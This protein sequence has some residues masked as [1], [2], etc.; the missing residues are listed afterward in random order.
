[1]MDFDD[2]EEPPQLIA[3]D[4]PVSGPSATPNAAAVT[5]DLEELQ[6]KKVPITIVTG[7]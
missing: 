6:L 3:I 2:E 4:A 5:A 1:M 7:R